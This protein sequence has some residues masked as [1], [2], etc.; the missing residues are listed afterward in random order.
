MRIIIIKLSQH[1]SISGKHGQLTYIRAYQGSVS[2]GDTLINARTGKRNRVS[3]L[4]Q[5]HSDKM[6]D[7]AESKAGDICAFFGIDCASG[8]TFVLDKNQALS[9]E[10]IYVPEPVISMSIKPTD[11]KHSDNFSKAVQRFTKEDPTF[12]VQWDDDV[13]E[14]VASGMVRSSIEFLYTVCTLNHYSS[15]HRVSYILTFMPKELKESTDAQ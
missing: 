13:K 2:R 8:D 12:R 6:E 11:K 9:M 4:V 14:T 1:I 7:V 15:S 5:M 3:R 10:S